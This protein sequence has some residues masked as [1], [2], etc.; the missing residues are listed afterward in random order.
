MILPSQLTS[1]HLQTLTLGHQF[2]SSI[3]LLPQTLT[4]LIIIDDAF[5]QPIPSLPRLTHLS[6]RSFAFNQPLSHLASTIIGLELGRGIQPPALPSLTNLKCDGALLTSIPDSLTSLVC[7]NP[8]PVATDVISDSSISHLQ[9]ILNDQTAPSLPNSLKTLV[10]SGIKE[11][12]ELNDLPM[13]LTRLEFDGRSYVHTANK[14]PAS[15]T[16]LM[17]FSCVRPIDH[18]PPN[19]THLSFGCSFNQSITG[20]LPQPLQSLELGPSFFQ[21]LRSLP[22]SLKSLSGGLFCFVL[23]CFVLFCFVLFCFVLFCFVLF[24]FVLFCFF[25]SFEISFAISSH[26]IHFSYSANWDCEFRCWCANH[27]CDSSNTCES[28]SILLCSF[29]FLLQLFLILILG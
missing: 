13:S 10:L 18:L 1:F 4:K 20:K 5:N 19:L 8:S 14:L 23:F 2:N 6:I 16:H 25:Q 29:I 27:D 7:A 15:L 9:L 26:P 21:P 24:C 22:P 12:T 28:S 17:L 3:D 11:T